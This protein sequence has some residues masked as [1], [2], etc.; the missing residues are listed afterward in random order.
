MCEAAAQKGDLEHAGGP[1]VA[2]KAAATAHE[3]VIFLA[4]QACANS[5]PRH[6]RRQAILN[7]F[8]V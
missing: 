1:D 7:W 6:L 3:A 2:D 4:D 5:L 8:Y